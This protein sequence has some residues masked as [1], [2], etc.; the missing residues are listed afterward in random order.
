MEN[1]FKP[2]KL[3]PDM[4]RVLEDIRNGAQNA[5]YGTAA[6]ESE[7]LFRKH[8]ESLITGAGLPTMQVIHYRW[9]LREVARL[10]RTRQGRDLAFHLE[11]CLRKWKSL[12]LESHSIQFLLCEAHSRL[13]ARSATRSSNDE[14]GTKPVPTVDSLVLR[15]LVHRPSSGNLRESV[16]NGPETLRL[17]SGRHSVSSAKSADNPSALSVHARDRNLRKSVE[18]VDDPPSPVS[19]DCSPV[20]SPLRESA[21]S[22]KSADDPPAPASAESADAC[23]SVAGTLPGSMSGPRPPATSASKLRAGGGL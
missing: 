9:F 21:E 7:E 6:P 16:D 17:R 10:W 20:P 3:S 14:H 4:N 23:A 5:L 2:M 19:V 1:L 12:G 22:A 18:S 15:P 8:V 13:K 11:L